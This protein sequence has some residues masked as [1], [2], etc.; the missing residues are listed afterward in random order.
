MILWILIIVASLVFY[1]LAYYFLFPAE[2]I[3]IVTVVIFVSILGLVYRA[4]FR[5]YRKRQIELREGLE[6]EDEER[7]REHK[8]VRQK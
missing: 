8:A 1:Y 4:Y 5:L 2:Y 7:H 3:Y 6:R